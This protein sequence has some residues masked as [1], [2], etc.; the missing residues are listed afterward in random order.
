[1]NKDIAVNIIAIVSV[2]INLVAYN[3]WLIWTFG[4]VCK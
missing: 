1:M 2:F 3:V 4:G